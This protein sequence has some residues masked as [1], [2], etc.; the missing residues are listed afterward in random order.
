MGMC[1]FLYLIYLLCSLFD[2]IN[3]EKFD[4]PIANVSTTWTNSLALE[5]SV[6]FT[7]GSS[8]RAILLRGATGFYGPSFACGFYCNG[9]CSSFHFAVFIVYTN[10]GSRIT[11]PNLG[12]PQLVWSANPNKPVKENSTLDLTKGGLALRDADGVLV[13]ST[14]ITGS[15]IVGLNMTETGNLVLYDS[16]N[17][18]LWQS[19]DDPT[20]ALVPGQKLVLGKS[21]TAMAN[22]AGDNSFA[23][24]VTNTGLF[25]S[26]NSDPPQF[27]YQEEVTGT[28]NSTK[29]SYVRFRNGSL[30]L[31]ILSA[32]PNKPD[33]VIST[34]LA[35]S[36]QY[37][38]LESDGHLK[39]Y[40]WSDLSGWIVVADLLTGI[41]AECG[42]PLVCGNYGICSNG[43][44]SCPGPLGTGG[45]D[46]TTFR[47]L[48]A[49]QPSLGCSRITPLSCEDTKYHRLVDLNDIMYFYSP[50]DITRTDI[51]SCKNA[52]LTNCS[53]EA[54]LF[55]YGSNSSDG[56][57]YLPTQVFSLVNN[58]KEETH[59]NSSAFIK[60]QVSPVIPSS[61]PS[62]DP[63][64]KT[65]GTATIVGSS[66]GATVG[67][68]L[69]VFVI[70]FL[71]RKKKN[72][73]EEDDEEY[74]DLVPGMPT[75]FAYEDLK[76]ATNNFSTQLGQ[77]GFGSVYEGALINGTKI[78]VKCLDGLGQVKKSFLAEVETIGSVHHVNLV[79]LVGFCVDKTHRLLVYEY[80]CNGSLEKWIFP[81]TEEHILDWKTRQ[82]II[83]DIAKGLTYLHEQCRQ[84]IVH[85]DIKPQNILLDANF[86][87]K[88][89]DFG[90]SK[91]IERDGGEVMTTMRGTPGYMAPEWLSSVITE[92]VDVYSFGIVVMEIVCGRKNLDR[93]QP[94]ERMHLLRLLKE[95]KGCNIID[96]NSDDMLLHREETTEMMKVAAWCLQSDFAR[97]P[98]M[99]V[100]VKVLEGVMEVEPSLD[101]NFSSGITPMTTA[102]DLDKQVQ[103]RDSTPLLPSLLS[104]PR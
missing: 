29:P 84:K 56:D 78:A 27:Y 54:A 62:S 30:A 65:A 33:S 23:L 48:S 40:E 6:N 2:P 15:N 57:C 17:Y 18:T 51:G 4:Y 82:S 99:S 67:V 3:A 104:G 12:F 43:Q 86:N 68:S 26:I 13:W 46:N 31:F 101:Y 61:S 16:K 72:V 100:V 39:V 66:V 19:F 21:L 44:C 38:K 93:S 52:C 69:L 59:Y 45:D 79:R 24:S 53:C 7:D 76:L 103:F 25:A 20:D 77:G 14:N 85:L 47:Q 35:S 74:L 80:M 41:L 73:E 49:R 96:K 9:N 42:Y 87:A 37:M 55:Q 50:P 36:M 64:F 60:V 70:L 75:R 28:K 22:K 98:S 58:V 8:V 34:P 102:K 32:E 83:S 90:L 5:H 1:C 10:S 88:V 91:L 71:I 89:S 97:R 95:D 63:K 11:N 92:K 81:K 94:E